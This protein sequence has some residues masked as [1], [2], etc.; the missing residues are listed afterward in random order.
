[1]SKKHSFKPYYIS[2]G[3]YWKCKAKGGKGRIKKITVSASREIGQYL[4]RQS[5]LSAKSVAV[6]LE[7]IG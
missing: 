6:K 5:S 4:R 1:M 3:R 2:G 7:D